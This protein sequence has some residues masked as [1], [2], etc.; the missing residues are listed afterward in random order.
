MVHF[1]PHDQAV[2]RFPALANL[3]TLNGYTSFWFVRISPL[4]CFIGSPSSC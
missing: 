4:P 3:K 2:T 1:M